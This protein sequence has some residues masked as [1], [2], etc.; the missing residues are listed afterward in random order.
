M[1]LLL[2]RSA[3][4]YTRSVHDE[5]FLRGI[6]CFNKGEYFTAHDLIEEVWRET[7]DDT[8]DF[9]QGLIQTAVAMHH[10]AR[11]NVAGACREYRF[12]VERL[13]SYRGSV[14]GVEVSRV[15]EDLAPLLGPLGQGEAVPFDASKAPVILVDGALPHVPMTYGPELMDAVDAFNTGCYEEARRRFGELAEAEE[16]EARAMFEW[17]AACAGTMIHPEH[18]PESVRLLHP[19]RDSH[20]GIDVVQLSGDLDRYVKHRGEAPIVRL[21]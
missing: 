17:L 20:L 8:K 11:G 15:L 13:S 2:W 18:Y 7:V 1:G 14:M 5:R 10:F 9:L 6:E 16:Q 12:A 21:K 3:I 19:L 4:G